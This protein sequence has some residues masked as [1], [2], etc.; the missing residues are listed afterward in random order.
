MTSR[1]EAHASIAVTLSPS[2][3]TRCRSSSVRRTSPAPDRRLLGRHRHEQRT[4]LDTR[5]RA[6]RTSPPNT[7][8]AH[9]DRRKPDAR[10]RFRRFE[11]R[12]QHLDDVEVALPRRR[13]LGWSTMRAVVARLRGCGTC[14]GAGTVTDRHACVPFFAGA[15]PRLMTCRGR[16]HCRSSRPDKSAGSSARRPR[17][18]WGRLVTDLLQRGESKPK[19]ARSWSRH[20]FRPLAGTFVNAA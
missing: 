12:R 11:R 19:R 9:V 20:H 2:T 10:G 1:G 7:G 14:S 16:T 4:A 17:R 3:T 18:W 8:I 5:L 6:R 15:L 13:S